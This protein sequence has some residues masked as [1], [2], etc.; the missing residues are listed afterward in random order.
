M[1]GNMCIYLCAKE[2][3][4][5]MRSALLAGVAHFHARGMCNVVVHFLSQL[6]PYPG[7]LVAVVGAPKPPPCF[8]GTPCSSP[9]P[10]WRFY[11][12]SVG[13]CIVWRFWFLFL[14]WL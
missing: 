13:Q 11:L 2:Q 6:L 1:Q 10:L 8:R 14:C 7:L 4:R 12:L 9:L 5:L 3:E